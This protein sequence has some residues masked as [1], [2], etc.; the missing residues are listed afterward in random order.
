MVTGTLTVGEIAGNDTDLNIAVGETKRILFS[1]VIPDESI[2]DLTAA[3]T[4]PAAHVGK[5][6]LGDAAIYSAG[7]N[8]R[9]IDK[10]M[11]PT[12]TSVYVYS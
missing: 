9:C 3:V 12:I 8:L 1:L 10:S 4:I 7:K 2:Y 5:L 11:A 6:E